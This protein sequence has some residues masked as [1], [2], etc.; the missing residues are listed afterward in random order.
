[1]KTI[2][3]Q[4]PCSQK[5]FRLF[6]S[7]ILLA[8]LGAQA[9][10]VGVG[11]YTNSL[12]A[13]P[14]AVDFAT[15]SI[16]GGSGDVVDATSLDAAVAVLTAAGI[17]AQVPILAGAPPAAAAT[18]IFNDTDK[19]LQTRPTGVKMHVILVTLTNQAGGNASSVSINYNLLQSAI[20]A[21]QVDGV[22]VYYSQTGLA[23][24]W[25]NIAALNATTAGLV[26]ANVTL[27]ATWNLNSPLY[28]LFADD[29]GSPSPDTANQID[30]FSAA[31]SGYAVQLPVALT[32]QPQSLT[33]DEGRPATF[34]AAAGGHPP[35]TFQ[36]YR[37]A[38]P[39]AGV[40]NASYTLAGTLAPDDGAIFSVVAANAASNVS[41]SV[42]SS[43]ATLTVLADNNPPVLLG[44]QL[45][46]L[47]KVLLRFSEAISAATV[48]SLGNYTLTNSNGSSFAITN[49]AF[50]GSQS[51]VLLDF[52]PAV[53]GGFTNTITVQG[54][55]DQSFAANLIPAGSRANFYIAAGVG[56]DPLHSVVINEFHYNPAFN[57][58][59]ES[60][61][62]IYNDTEAT[63]DLSGWSIRGG[64]D[65]YFPPGT[66]LAAHAF[67]VVA[68]NPAT[69]LSRY[70]VTAFG[71]WAGGLNNDGEQITLRDFFNDIVDEVD[72]KNEFPWP[73]AADGSGSSA[74]LANPTLDNDLG[75][76]W[77][78]A[79]PTPGATNLAFVTN[80]P[81]NIRQVN[82]APNSPRSTNQVTVTCKVTDP[83]G[84]A[85]VTLA[86]QIV[87]AG[88]FI[89]STLPL[90]TAQLNNLNAVPMTNALN[91][92][93]ELPANWTTVVM[94]DDGLNGDAVAGDDLFSVVLPAQASRTLIR[95][96]I[97]CTDSFF[98]ARRAPF[99]DD[100]SLNFA[101]WVYD[102]V[103]A[104][105][106]F[107]SAALQTLP[108]YTLVTRPAD[109]DQCTA[110]FNGADRLT[111]Q[112]VG[113][114]K[115]EARFYFNW[116]GA[117]VYDG[118]VYD[119]ITYRLRG[120]NGRYHDGKRSIRYKFKD[121]RFLAAKDQTGQRFPTKWP[122]LTTGK[123]Q[124]NRGTETY[125]LQEVVNYF[126]WNKVAVPAP[127]TLHFH[128]RVVRGA[129]ET[130][131]DQ[132]SGDFWGLSWA[133][134]K[135]D[136][137]FLDSHNLPKG[138]LYKLIDNFGPSL[139]ELRYQGPFA[140]SNAADMFNVENNLAGNQ[141]TAWLLAQA[142][143]TNWS[144]YHGVAEAIRHY[145][146]WPS[147]NKNG[148]YYFEPLYGA[149]NTFYGRMMQ[150]PYDGTDTW[151]PTWNA[152]QDILHNGIFN[153]EG[154]GENLE[155]QKEY[156]NTVREM[157][158]LLFQPDQ[159]Y[160]I[161]DAF[162]TPLT[163]VAAADR[164]RWLSAP[165]P[166]SYQ[167]LGYANSPGV[168]GGLPAMAQDMKNFMFVG[169]NKGWWVGG[170]NVGAGGWITR[171]DAV[172]NDAAIPVQPTI[173]FVGTPGHPVNGLTFQSSAFNDPQGAGTFS[174]LQWRIAEVLP[175]GTA[176]S[177]KSQ[178][179]LEWDAAWTSP[180]LAPFVSTNT[181][182]DYV[183]QAG[184]RYRA[185]VRHK[186]DTGR[187]SAWSAPAEF[188]PSPVDTT[189]ILKT[190]LVFNEIMYNPPPS[191]ATDGDE[192]EFIE[193]KNIG[194]YTLNLSGL[195][196]SQGVT[197]AFPIGTTLAPG[198][199]FL[200]ARN[201][202]VL[203]TRYPGAVV[204]GDYSD[205]L[206]N[207]S[208]TVTISH[209][210][211]G[212]IIS[213]NYG[214]RPPWPAPADGF[215]FSIVRDEATGEYG[216]SAALLGTPGA[217]GGL[218]AI[219][220]VLINEVLANGAPPQVDAIE[221]F[222]KGTN[223]VNLGGWF[224]TDSP[225]VPQK[226][227]IPPG[228]VIPPGGFLVFYETNS[229]GATNAFTAN[230][231]NAFGLGSLGDDVY[232]YSGDGTNLTG[233]AHG[234]NF[235]ASPTNVTYGRFQIHTGPD[236]F[237]LQLSNTLGGPNSGPFVGPVAGPIVINEF[238]YNPAVPNT[239]FIELFN[240]SPTQ[241]YDLSYWQLDGVS[242]TFPP[243]SFIGP[244]SYL[245]LA[246][247]LAAFA[248]EYGPA[249][250]V[251]GT[252]SGKLQNDG[253]TLTLIMPGPTPAQDVIVD[254]VRYE[255][256]APWS[257]NAHGTGSSL[258]L[259]D[260]FQDNSRAGNWAG[261]YLPVTSTPG[262]NLPGI[263]YP[264][265]TNYNLRFVSLTGTVATPSRLLLYLGDVGEVYLDDLYLASGNIAETGTNYISNG[266]FETPLPGA[267]ALTNFFTV[268]GLFHT[269]SV[270]AATNAHS[271]ASKRWAVHYL[272]PRRWPYSLLRLG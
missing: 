79:L 17:N 259:I 51:N 62:E 237:V 55:R 179:R 101:C 105:L 198:A 243:G 271:R 263:L 211:A 200:V 124:S 65:F 128:F 116:E 206:N 240:T 63:M 83:D 154:A 84:V 108:V 155:L 257:T 122:E 118:E 60:F 73:I 260:P 159:I 222:N 45:I 225:G 194:P 233:Y 205:K 182:P 150:L 81:P 137:G 59:R 173:S 160:S 192:F 99:E 234:F 114:A 210:T 172:A 262:T 141:T 40:T 226:F 93:F 255:S 11:G 95:Y 161:I 9:A 239:S 229:F 165:A 146:I 132:Y 117:M 230:G 42:T 27:A 269:N 232:L 61:I 193:L 78:S 267:P 102:G 246:A 29:N 256:T 36:W 249:I 20:L 156:R 272:L 136:S 103:P 162:A 107:S 48:T 76:S 87:T 47:N 265:F 219:G 227:I 120:A 64:V 57:P 53:V 144:R 10:S 68:E 145:D 72:F 121:G 235:G 183:A 168:T 109:L 135:Y 180:A 58:S 250:P 14:A 199:L 77:R 104:Y 143:Y 174:A 178:L 148:A 16:G 94:H 44:A 181:F 184:R 215:G 190:N 254:Q 204:N 34:T 248:A 125:A 189:S 4:P 220:G 214:D 90:T 191:G 207:D 5:L 21:E 223:L 228:T 86:Y 113:G 134:E 31:V 18:A 96:R 138:N 241:T 89:P 26:S 123:G 30:N 238:M 187:W 213:I 71:P 2:L 70:G 171:L 163:N 216:A 1:M 167:S 170:E 142:N 8:S 115:N 85:S 195:S 268:V 88:N 37:G 98:A 247:N 54:L 264:G 258:Q 3:P 111:T 69:V 130:G 43:V 15:A 224:L 166:A 217:N 106:G 186:D 209:P 131:A 82:H 52:S 188:T 251:F 25:S 12:A 127:N 140:V 129:S 33:V 151:G 196:F 22:R 231:A 46:G 119:H 97:T 152:G 244:Q 149:S 67:V 270:I 7:V 185:R 139:D 175:A 266:D 221:L 245:V 202:A 56:G 242:Y 28:L 92:A 74:Q 23:N 252:F 253:E 66:F 236:L 126:L 218:S 35:I 110:W 203:V 19:N 176:V 212:T 112:T 177:N 41:Y 147:A 153:D 24:S 50:S 75:S 49:A 158:A 80:A 169:G 208:E 91:P 164:L 201:P 100:P 13:Q 261:L 157:R 6:G 32:A 38:G 197:F 133:Q 39:V